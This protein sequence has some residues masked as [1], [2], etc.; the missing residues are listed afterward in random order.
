M[1]VPQIPHGRSGITSFEEDWRHAN[2]FAPGILG[3]IKVSIL[4]DYSIID[5]PLSVFSMAHI[6]MR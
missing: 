4:S 2:Y 5:V 3:E 6:A 1:N